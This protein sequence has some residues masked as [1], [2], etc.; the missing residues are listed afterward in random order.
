MEQGKLQMT[1]TTVALSLYPRHEG[2]DEDRKQEEHHTKHYANINYGYNVLMVSLLYIFLLY[3][4]RNMPNRPSVTSL[5]SRILN[6]IYSLDPVVHMCLLF[7][8]LLITFPT[9]YPF[10]RNMGLYI[11]RLGRLSYTL[12]PLNLILSLK[13][14]TFPFNQGYTYDQ[15]I[16]LHKWLSR[17]I[18]VIGIIHGVGFIVKWASDPTVSFS[19]KCSNPQNIIGIVILIMMIFSIIL[20][21]GVMR[22]KNYAL[23]YV[24]HKLVYLAF[25]FG[26]PLHA[27]PGVAKPYIWICCILLILHSL[28]SIILSKRVKLN[29]II[30]NKISPDSTTLSILNIPRF[31]APDVFPPGTHLRISPYGCFN[32]LF[33]LLPSHPYTICSSPEDSELRL[34]ITE[35]K[36]KMMPEKAY[37]VLGTYP[38]NLPSALIEDIGQQILIVCGGSGIGYGLA[39]FEYFKHNTNVDSLKI[40]WLLKKQGDFDFLK[41]NLDMRDLQEGENLSIFITGEGSAAAQTLDGDGEAYEMQSNIHTRRI[42]WTEDLDEYL[43]NKNDKSWMICCG[44]ESLVHDACEFAEVNSINFISEFYSI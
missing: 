9:S 3:A 27:R 39:I 42:N 31:A 16:P 21:I 2:H 7:I 6:K 28:D 10:F 13:P 17:L 5:H 25:I 18:F 1:I 14:P 32:P 20:S 35:T 4:L 38:S 34:I 36:F 26:V 37:T 12:V 15:F 29:S 24:V 19:E 44:P 40:V 30:K 23:F 43:Q 11:K 22:R 33:W 41:S 8:P